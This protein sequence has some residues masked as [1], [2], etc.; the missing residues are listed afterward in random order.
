MTR[1]RLVPFAV[2][3]V[4]LVLVGVGLLL[5]PESIEGAYFSESVSARPSRLDVFDPGRGPLWAGAGAATVVA[6]IVLAVVGRLR[7]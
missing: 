2:I 7:G 5:G 6:G 3:A 4:G 1:R